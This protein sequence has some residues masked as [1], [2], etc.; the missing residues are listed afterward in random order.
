[1]NG[2]QFIAINTA[3]TAF[4]LGYRGNINAKISG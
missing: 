4:Q 3:G 2:R 1:M